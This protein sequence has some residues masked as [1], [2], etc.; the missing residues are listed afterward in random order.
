MNTLWSRFLQ[1]S[2]WIRMLLAVLVVLGLSLCIAGVGLYNLNRVF[3]SEN[4]F[5]SEPP[6]GVPFLTM[7][8]MKPSPEIEA[9]MASARRLNELYEQSYYRILHGPASLTPE[10]RASMLEAVSGM[11]GTSWMAIMDQAFRSS[12]QGDRF[13]LGMAR[14]RM[15]CLASFSVTLK[16]DDPRADLSPILQASIRDV[17]LAERLVP[18][19]MGK[20]V[21]LALSGRMVMVVHRLIRSG[22]VQPSEAAS[23]RSIF[24]DYQRM[25]IS[26]NEALAFEMEFIEN[27]STRLYARA[28]L[29]CWLLERIF[30]D[31]VSEFR[32]MMTGFDVL[33]TTRFQAAVSGIRHP[34]AQI[35]IPNL[36]RS[37][38]IYLQKMARE[39][40]LM[41]EL[42]DIENASAVKCIDPY[43]KN[44][45]LTRTIDGRTLYYA[46]GPNGRDDEMSGDDVFLH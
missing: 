2:P 35:M 7:G 41:Q 11:A 22:L 31:P 19:L 24:A 10:I 3:E 46:A 42:R 12:H 1:V 18:N 33:D 15:R 6:D 40:I 29:G 36:E 20:M 30:G 44:P 8:Q 5:E 26:L 45:L 28:P 27:A 32:K 17:I 13:N 9:F 4:I 16:E 38:E 37:R 23:L 25:R 34:L 14:S 21:S 39:E 43:T